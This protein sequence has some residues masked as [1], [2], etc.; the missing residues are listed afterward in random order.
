MWTAFA[1]PVCAS[2]RGPGWYVFD[3]AVGASD[4]RSVSSRSSPRR[5]TGAANTSHLDDTTLLRATGV[6]KR[7]GRKVVLDGVSLTVDRGE[8]V[9][10]VG[11]NGAGKTTLLRVSAGL[12]APD[13]GRVARVDRVGYCPQ[14]AGL[15]DLLT[16]DDHIELFGRAIGL[17][18]ADARRVGQALLYDLDFRGDLGAPVGKL[19]GGNQ[20]KLNLALALIGDPELLLLDEP[21]QGFD[22]GTYVDF[23]DL[24]A[25]WR[26]HGRGV[27]IVTHLLTELHRVDRVFGVAAAQR[28]SRSVAEP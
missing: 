4:T 3:N 20:Q 27:A 8:V 6:T 28:A 2:G 13:G 21:Y 9:A 18:P 5:L 12:L 19:S 26:S 14:N 15:V 17:S 16:A 11:E 24:V 7:F 23:W 10:V 1:W 25:G 22:H